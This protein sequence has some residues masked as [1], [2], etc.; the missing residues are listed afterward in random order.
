MKEGLLQDTF[1]LLDL[2]ATDRRCCLE[3]DK[4]RAQQ[5]LLTRHRSK[6]E[7]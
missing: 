4:K 7:R 2:R 6:D 3:E 5:R 1:Q